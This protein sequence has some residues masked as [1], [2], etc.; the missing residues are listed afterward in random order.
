MNLKSGVQSAPATY[1]IDGEQ[2]VAITTGWGGSWALNWG[3]AW[4]DAVAPDVG[5]VFV[6]KLGGEGV[7][8]DPMEL[9]VTEIPKAQSFGDEATIMAGFTHYAENCM[10]C[11]GP[12]AISSGVLPDLR[13]S[14][15]AA[16]ENSWSD[17][18]LGGALTDNGMVSFAPNLSDEQAES[19]RAYVLDQAW[20]AVANGDAKAPA[21][22]E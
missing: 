3:F 19:I 17:I 9:I 12:L 4:N 10:V 13:W 1:E 11:H 21:H 8:P 6:F 14:Y 15:V 16:D 5:R 20:L 7:V 22:N 18:V 2:Y